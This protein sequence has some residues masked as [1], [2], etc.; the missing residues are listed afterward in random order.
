MTACSSGGPRRGGAGPGRPGRPAR[1]RVPAAAAE[2]VQLHAEPDQIVQGVDVDV[3]GDDGRHGGVAGDGRGGVAVEPG[4]VAGAGLGRGRA[5]GRP[6]GPD[7]RGP[8]FLQRRV[9]VEQQQVG[10]GDVDPGLDRLPGPLGHQV[11]R[12]QPAHRFLERVVVPLPLGPVV[13]LPGRGGQRVQ[14]GGD[15]GGALGGQVPVHDPGAADGGGQ[16]HLP[17]RE[18]PARILIRQVPA[19]PH[20]HL[21]E[22]ARQIRQPQASGEGGEQLLVAQVPVIAGELV[23][24]QADHPRH[25]FGD[26]PGGQRGQYP[27]VGGGPLGPRAVPDGGAA[28]DPG[29]VDQPGHRAVVPVPGMALPGGERGQEPGPRRRR[30]R[31]VLLQLGQAFGLG[32]GG[33]LGGVGGGEVA[34]PGADHVQRLTDTGKSRGSAHR[35]H[36]PAGAGRCWRRFSSPERAGF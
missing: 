5:A 22:Q 20:E 35:G 11:R 30:N 34:Q 7:L 23:G 15:R 32:G 14:H 13:F 6:P 19:G 18:L 33:Q 9:A 25:R 21:R 24:P 2:P 4:A 10:Q 36:L 16:L 28:G 17:V 31:V 8:F 12:G 27:R 3:A 26:L 29:P 1:G